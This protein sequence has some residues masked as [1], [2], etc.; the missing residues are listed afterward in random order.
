MA[1]WL[2]ISNTEYLNIDLIERIMVQGNIVQVLYGNGVPKIYQN[3]RGRLVLSA[4]GILQA[5][6]EVRRGRPPKDGNTRTE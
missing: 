4:T 3:E 1:T 6:R 5:E 2:K